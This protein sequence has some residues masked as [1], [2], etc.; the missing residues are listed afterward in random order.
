MGL[1]S[2]SRRSDAW[3][4]CV[5]SLLSQIVRRQDKRSSS[6]AAIAARCAFRVPQATSINGNGTRCAAEWARSA[7]ASRFGL[8]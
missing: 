6:P 3:L 1:G 4:A 8:G 5:G 2:T 7:G